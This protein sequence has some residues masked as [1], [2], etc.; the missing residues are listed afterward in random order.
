MNYHNQTKGTAYW[1][2]Q[3][4]F[5]L[6]EPEVVCIPFHTNSY[7]ILNETRSHEKRVKFL[8]FARTQFHGF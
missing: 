1:L 7:R 3:K 2:N 4:W 8:D 6:S 5:I